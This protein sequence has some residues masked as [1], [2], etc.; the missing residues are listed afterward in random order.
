MT[1]LVR[2]ISRTLLPG[3]ALFFL[4]WNADGQTTAFNYAGSLNSNGTPANGTYDFQFALYQVA[5]GGAAGAVQPVNNVSVSGGQFNV[6]LD[7]GDA[8]S[9]GGPRYLEISV[10]PSGNNSFV[11]T[12]PRTAILSSPYAITAKT[13]S[14]PA[15]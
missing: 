10:S 12:G 5:T 14:L 9:D 4:A 15:H 7:F 3:L 13:L 2:R 8:F 6:T 1:T 11:V